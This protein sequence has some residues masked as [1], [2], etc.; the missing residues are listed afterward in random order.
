MSQARVL[1]CGLQEYSS[2]IDHLT[3]GLALQ[4]WMVQSY[5]QVAG[6]DVDGLSCA[7][8][9]YTDP[10]ARDLCRQ[11]RLSPDLADLPVVAVVEDPWSP[12]VKDAFT[13]GVDDYLPGWSL[14]L[15]RNK[16]MALRT[17]GAP[18]GTYLSG[19]VVLADPD[20]ERRV[21][22]AR[23][24]RKMG[25]AVEFAVDQT[26]PCGTEV[27]L[28]VAHADLPPDGAAQCLRQYR[29]GPGSRVPWIITGSDATLQQI[30]RTVGPSEHV[31][32]CD[33]DADNA[34]VVFAANKLL[35]GAGRA[36]RRSERLPYE[37]S[38]RVLIPHNDVEIWGYTYNINLGGLYVRTLTP[39]ALGT[40][41]QLEFVPPNGR[42]RV[43][44]EGKAVWRQE[45]TPGKGYPA[46]F[47]VQYIE[48][49]LPVADGAALEYGYLKLCEEQG[50]EAAG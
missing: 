7:L 43:Q 12:D 22:L 46:G 28:V 23:H 1:V 24:L 45:Y 48:D 4:A 20:Q 27:K 40:E 2:V 9:A 42:G 49:R 5:E 39:P 18:A 50:S 32:Y 11:I 36:L 41:V 13:V 19:V 3:D 35:I 21:G 30:R 38:V 8:V 25:L 26:I 29:E 15:A 37:T 34:Q 17:E 44:V 47:G 31:A 6:E 14:P 10:Q 33:L 16:L